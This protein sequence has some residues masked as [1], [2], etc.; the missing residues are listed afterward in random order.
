MVSTLRHA[1]PSVCLTSLATLGGLLASLNSAIVAVKRFAV[2]SSFSVLC[3]VIYVLTVMPTLLH[4]AVDPQRRCSI[5]Q[6]PRLPLARICTVTRLRFLFPPLLLSIIIVSGYLI[7]HAGW[8]AFPSGSL[9]P[10]FYRSSHPTEVYRLRGGDLAWAEHVLRRHRGFVSLHAVW[11]VQPHDSRDPW[12]WSPQDDEEMSWQPLWRLDFNITAP[13]S[14]NWLSG[15]CAEVARM[16]HSLITPSIPPRRS[17]LEEDVLVLSSTHSHDCAFGRSVLSFQDFAETHPTCNHDITSCLTAFAQVSASPTGLRF[18][19]D[20]GKIVGLVITFTAN[21]SL[22]NTTFSDLQKFSQSVN[23]WFAAIQSTAPPGLAGGFLV[24]PELTALEVYEDVL[25]FLPLSMSLSVALATLLV[26][27]STLNITISVT[28]LVSV[29]A[30]LFVSILLLVF[31][32]GWSLG[33]VEAL[34]LSL[35]A[36]LAV[37]PCIHLAF[38]IIQANGEKFLLSRSPF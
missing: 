22:P 18:S 6:L 13:E 17:Y 2:Y 10:A 35:S 25:K 7:F 38:A 1:V 8:L 31:L 32:G 20:T 14:L 4:L 34:I 16:P 23:S 27:L 30:A 11:G 28:A 9:Q 24:S 12:T 29:V 21:L 33:I 36:G 37:D 5:L 19:T 15:F 26:F 3:H